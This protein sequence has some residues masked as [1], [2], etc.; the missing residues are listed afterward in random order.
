MSSATEFGTSEVQDELRGSS[1]WKQKRDDQRSADE[2]RIFASTRNQPRLSHKTS[3][4]NP[5]LIN[6][7]FSSDLR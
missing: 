6:L 7:Q 1:V 2:T 5:Q 3:D 4:P